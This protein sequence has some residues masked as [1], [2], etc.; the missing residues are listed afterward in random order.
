MVGHA[1]RRGSKSAPNISSEFA[2]FALHISVHSFVSHGWGFR[3]GEFT[4]PECMR[5]DTEKGQ[6]KRASHQDFLQL[7]DRGLTFS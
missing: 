6:M 7:S 5:G 3:N 4:R 1:W 2:L